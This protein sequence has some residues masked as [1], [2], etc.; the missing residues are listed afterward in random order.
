MKTIINAM[1]Y[2]VWGSP[3]KNTTKVYTAWN[4]PESIVVTDLDTRGTKVNALLNGEAI[5][6]AGFQE[7][8]GN[9]GWT[10]WVKSKL[11]EKYA[12]V[13]GN[14]TDI[15]SGVYIIYRKDML[16]VLDNGLFWL[17]DGAPNS[18][19]KY[20]K[21]TFQRI[22]NWGC[23]RI[24]KTG[25]VFVFMNAHLD[26]VAEVR[27][28]QA[29]VITSQIPSIVNSVR[30]KFDVPVCPVILVGDMNAR[31]NTEEYEIITSVLQDSIKI[32][33]GA[34]EDINLSSCTGCW[35][36]ES[37]ADYNKVGFRIDYIFVSKDN[38]SVLNYKMVQTSTNISPYGEYSSDHN[39]VI[40][41]LEINNN[42]NDN[43]KY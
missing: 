7:V 26:T 40:A 22:C 38:C 27:P 29:T 2:N 42:R 15:K 39:A 9:T 30:D 16:E 37:D 12:Y 17:Y 41:Q 33:S 10:E 18:P 35:Y 3:P 32:S 24:K 23:F 8:S 1:S 11:D 4:N 13:E 20:E 34:T 5:D 31:P 6:I 43:R 21:S 14:T 19:K 28:L 25:E 36:C